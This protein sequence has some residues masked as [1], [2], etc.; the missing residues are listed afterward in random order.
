[1][2]NDVG[3]RPKGRRRFENT[4]KICVEAVPCF[5]I[6]F[7]RAITSEP[8]NSVA[9]EVF[10]T[11]SFRTISFLSPVRERLGDLPLSS[12]TR[13]C[14][15][16]YS[17]TEKSRKT[18]TIS[19]ILVIVRTQN[20]QKTN[21]LLEDDCVCAS[22][23]RDIDNVSVNRKISRTTQMNLSDRYRFG[24][25]SSKSLT[26]VYNYVLL[27]CTKRVSRFQNLYSPI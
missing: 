8:L 14:A 9:I 25:N 2:W 19:K 4:Q 27:Q 22:W 23:H 6:T 5:F 12:Q 3:V 15:D 1:M 7:S 17:D 20:V 11:F 24:W 26:N 13:A 21:S 16:I 10:R 18:R